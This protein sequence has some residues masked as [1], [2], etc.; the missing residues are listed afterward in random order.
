[1]LTLDVVALMIRL[2]GGLYVLWINM[3]YEPGVAGSDNYLCVFG[4]CSDWMRFVVQPSLFAASAKGS[5]LERSMPTPAI[6]W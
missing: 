6:A 3:C 5:I 4:F 1:M 2:S